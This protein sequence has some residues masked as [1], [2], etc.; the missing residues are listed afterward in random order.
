MPATG[1][2]MG[3]PASISARLPPQ[4]VAIDELP[5]D[6]ST[7]DTTRIVYG[8]S[9][10]SGSIGESARSASAPWPISRR[11]GARRDFISPVE[12]GGKL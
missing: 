2:L 9:S 1:A 7:S 5:L 6:S 10:S 8:K 12:N 11:D 4:T 3:T